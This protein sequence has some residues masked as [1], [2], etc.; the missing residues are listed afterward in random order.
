MILF[1]GLQNFYAR[2]HEANELPTGIVPLRNRD[3]RI[4]GVGLSREARPNQNE[5]SG[6]SSPFL[7]EQCAISQC[8]KIKYNVLQNEFDSAHI[9]SLPCSLPYMFFNRGIHLEKT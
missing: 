7:A 2:T 5:K 1:S 4:A 9:C 3:T 6:G 8:K